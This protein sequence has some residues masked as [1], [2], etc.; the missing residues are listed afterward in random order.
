MR[1]LIM[2]LLL[3]GVF[4]TSMAQPLIVT[5]K[6]VDTLEKKNLQ[7]AVI[8][9]LK[10]SDSTLYLFSR[11]NKKGEF[12]LP[13]VNPGNYLLL[14]SYPGFADFS[15]P[16]EVKN[17]PVN[18]LGTIPMTLK[19]K[20]MELVVIKSAP[21]I[22]LRGDT[23]E[24]FADSFKVKE[25]ATVEELLKKLP[26]FQVNSKGEITAQGQRVQKV[27]VDGEEFFGDDP[28]MA[29]QNISAK[30][31]DKVQV[32]DTKTE[33]Q[34][35]KGIST[36]TEGKTVN[37]K[38]KE[39]AK[40]GS[41][42]KMHAGTDFDRLVDAKLLLNRFTGKKKVSVYGTKTNLSAGSLNWEDRQKLG[43]EPDFE[44]DELAGYYF[45][46]S[47][48]DEFSEW[49]LRG[50]PDSYTAGG[51]FN[52][53]WNG[54]R[55]SINSSYRFNRLQ[56]QNTSSSY[57]QNLLS[58]GITYRNKFQK[59]YGINQQHAANG[60]YDWKLDSFSTIRFAIAGIYKKTGVFS[61][62]Y[63]EFLNDTGTFINRSTQVLN[64][65]TEKKQLD[66]IIT[67]KRTF[68][69]PNRQLVATI[70]YGLIND[71]QQGTVATLTDFYK[72]NSIDSVDNADQLKLV[73]GRAH[74]FGSKIT[75]SEPLNAFWALVMDYGF[76][77][78]N[79]SSYRNTF[80]KDPS[81]KYAIRDDEFS[82]NFDL[83]ASSNSGS[84]NLRFLGK[85]LKGSFGSGFSAIQ[86]KLFDLDSNKRNV[87]YFKNLAPQAAMSY[88]IKRQTRLSVNYRGTTSQPTIDQLQPVRNNND[89]LN[90]F[91]GNP[92]LKVG[93]NHNFN[94]GYNS[95][96]TL[97]QTY[98]YANF[99]YII[100]VN[101]ISFY[102][103]VDISRGKQ[104]YTPVNVSGNR[105]WNTWFNIS[106]ETEDNKFSYGLNVSASGGKN[107]NFIDE[108]E[109]GIS[110]KK[111]NRT[112][113]M[114]SDLG[115]DFRIGDEETNSIE[116]GP[117][118]GYNI[119]KSSLRPLQNSNYWNYGGEIDVLLTLPGKLEF[120][121]NCNLDLRQ[122]ISGF[123]AN[124]SQIL[125]KANLTKKIFK[126]NS[127][128]LFLI[129][130]DILDQNRGFN[131]R[132]TSN[133]ISEERYSRISRY[134]LV[135]FEWSFNKM[136]GGINK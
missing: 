136:N 121:T 111:R 88:A 123:A 18:D 49:S 3:L 60:K 64:N 5:G 9:L 92:D 117:V 106:K 38:L 37:I 81:G 78:N 125:W 85:K 133:F 97:G 24:F 115:I 12:F 109:N 110:Q 93:F 79:S 74:T 91:I 4:Q 94:L 11:S 135:K 108:I 45:S 101:A 113:Y 118:I 1:K 53:K 84:V 47:G 32:F 98:F 41:F 122:H 90:I 50:L 68:K 103:S 127:G 13:K 71:E 61:D 15:D 36:G 80:D 104:T 77:K 62:T 30:A 34:N 99:G 73:D 129:A 57:T 69:K 16:V 20:L 55:N 89:R 82:N 54:D 17:D 72:N 42:G 116:F 46:F 105:S 51:L 114:N 128:K 10:K 27:L 43:I 100:P 22:R 126:N 31:V 120:T 7:N 6:I 70:R 56:T 2:G 65:H 63:S 95:Y 29:T 21:A 102:N 107:Y 58:S 8:A 19:S 112:E 76:N 130:N 132:I 33:E 119:S 66:N 59:S 52:N 23:T 44:Y 40:K 28:T 48:G 39:E 87:Y 35:L 67:Y 134:F 25:G 131:R 96:K 26:G 124:P 83:D 86:L 75:F 14:V